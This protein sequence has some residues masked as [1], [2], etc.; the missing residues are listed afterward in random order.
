M[1]RDYS[2]VTLRPPVFQP[3]FN[4]AVGRHV[5]TSRDFDEALKRGAEEQNTSYTRIDPCDYASITPTKD[6]EIIET[7]ARTRRDRGLT[8]PSTSTVIPL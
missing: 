4:H 5:E 7:Q 1:V 6:T 8:P 2:T 3:H